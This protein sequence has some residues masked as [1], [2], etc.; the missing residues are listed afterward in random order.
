MRGFFGA[1]AITLSTASLSFLPL[2]E[3]ESLLFTN[4][5]LTALASVLVGYESVSWSMVVSAIASTGESSDN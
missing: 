1:G 4:T 2:G 3:S 5:A